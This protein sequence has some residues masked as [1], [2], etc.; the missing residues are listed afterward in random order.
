[1]IKDYFASKGWL[2]RYAQAEDSRGMWQKYVD[3]VEAERV[4]ESRTMELAQV[5]RS[6]MDNFN[7]PDLDQGA[8]SILR[9]GETLEDDFDVSFRRPNAEGRSRILYKRIYRTKNKGG[10]DYP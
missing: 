3:E 4:Q 6:E 10:Y 9:P 1:M 5:Q 2:T 7:T 8:D